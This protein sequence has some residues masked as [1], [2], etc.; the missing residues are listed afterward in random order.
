MACQINSSGFVVYWTYMSLA[1]HA[2]M[3]C[4]RGLHEMVCRSKSGANMVLAKSHIMN[5]TM[6]QSKRK[7]QCCRVNSNFGFDNLNGSGLD[8][9]LAPTCPRNWLRVFFESTFNSCSESNRSLDSSLASNHFARTLPR[10]ANKSLSSWRKIRRY[11]SSSLS[12]SLGFPLVVGFGEM[13]LKNKW[14]D[15]DLF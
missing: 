12:L 4:C 8:V 11:S 1:R 15:A 10:S 9:L 3:I 13:A 5:V 2:S 14:N 6:S 7:W